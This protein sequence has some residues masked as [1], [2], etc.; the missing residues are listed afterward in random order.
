MGDPLVSGAQTTLGDPR[1][2]SALMA[3]VRRR[4][5]AGEVEEIVQAT[6]TE[7][8]ASSHRPEDGEPLRKWVHGIARHKIADFHRRSRREELGVDDDVVST[9]HETAHGSAHESAH[10]S[11]HDAVDLLR[12][13]E[14][15]APDQPGAERTLEWMMREGEGEKLESIAL[16]DAVPAPQVRQRV[17]RMRRHF[18]ARWA[19]QIAA[20]AAALIALLLW[21][22]PT[23]KPND[24]RP[25][26][27]LVDP[28]ARGRAMR[29]EALERCAERQWE[30]CLRGLDG[31]KLLDPIG[32]DDPAVIDARAAANQVQP[33]APPPRIVLP[34]TKAP[35]MKM[36]PP[37]PKA[38]GTIAPFEPPLKGGPSKPRP[39]QNPK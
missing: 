26:P 8:I 35:P 17:S 22:F 6:L 19:A 33:V 2:R 13:A 39:K 24:L 7:A 14:R 30:P 16:S 25:L 38:T 23:P 4:V 18:R 12:W 27:E 31:A 9:A 20:A 10:E 21:L 5:P 37:A 15:E 29:R 1:L 11:S 3:M 32:D 28:I 34:P 36:L